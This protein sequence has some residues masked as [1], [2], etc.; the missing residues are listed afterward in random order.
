MSLLHE[1]IHGAIAENS[2]E[3][4]ITTK[5]VPFWGEDSVLPEHDIVM[6]QMEKRWPSILKGHRASLKAAKAD[7]GESSVRFISNHLTAYHEDIRE[8]FFTTGSEMVHLY[9]LSQTKAN[10]YMAQQLGLRVDQVQDLIDQTVGK[11]FTEKEI[12]FVESLKKSFK[13]H[14]PAVHQFNEAI[15]KNW[16]DVVP[17]LLHWA[18]KPGRLNKLI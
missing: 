7:V 14:M 15:A 18:I 1:G 5:G 3:T 13:T 12:K 17:T 11:P 16:D 2:G 9:R 8:E 6:E 4:P 10:D